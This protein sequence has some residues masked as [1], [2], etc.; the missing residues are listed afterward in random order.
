MTTTRRIA[1]T[2]CNTAGAVAGLVGIALNTSFLL[3]SAKL[4]DVD[5]SEPDDQPTELPDWVDK[6]RT[7]LDR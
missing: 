2:W 7:D 6:M 1:V 5:L 3:V 4:A